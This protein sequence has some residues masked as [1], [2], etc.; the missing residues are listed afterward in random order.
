MTDDDENKK[1][2]WDLKDENDDLVKTT[3]SL[4]NQI[5]DLEEEKEHLVDEHIDAMNKE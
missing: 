1:I 5:E 2:I 4:K 3:N